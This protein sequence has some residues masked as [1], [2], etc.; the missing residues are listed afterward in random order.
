M[1]MDMNGCFQD[2]SSLSGVTFSGLTG[3]EH[4]T[5]IKEALNTLKITNPAI[6]FSEGTETG[7]YNDAPDAEYGAMLETVR[8][9]RNLWRYPDDPPGVTQPEMNALAL[10][11]NALELVSRQ[12]VEL[13]KYRGKR[14]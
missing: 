14:G 13:R 4:V 9:I 12:D 5:S 8:C 11:A 6:T 1:N 3:R 10:L 7:L 2:D